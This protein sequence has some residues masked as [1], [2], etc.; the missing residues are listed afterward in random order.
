MATASILISA[1]FIPLLE[2]AR[3]YEEHAQGKAGNH[4]R[5]GGTSAPRITVVPI[6][7]DTAIQQPVIRQPG[8]TNI[9]T[10]GSLN[11]PP[12]ADG[13]RWFAQHIF[14]KVRQQVRTATLTIIGKNPPEELRE[15]NAHHP[16]S[17]FVTGFVPDLRPYLERS[18]LSVIPVRAGSGM[19]V[20]IL[21]MFSLGMPVIT[22]TIGL[23]GIE[24]APG[25][26]VLVAD[27]PDEFTAAV[28]RLFEDPVLQEQ[29]AKNGRRLA[30]QCYDWRA[31]LRKL[32]DVY[33]ETV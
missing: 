26:D 1:S 27:T 31:A 16:D 29:L 11:Y 9:L 24:A 23:E 5:S 13:I 19:R 22:T 8:S 3:F 6:A 15:L 10:L 18:A 20:R 32:N 21:D 28:I 12:N 7:V 17:I 4:S 25:R 33:K 14:P 2:A 30:E